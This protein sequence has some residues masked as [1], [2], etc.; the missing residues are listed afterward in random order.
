MNFIYSFDAYLTYGYAQPKNREHLI[1]EIRLK[2]AIAEHYFYLFLNWWC[3][4]CRT[5][6]QRFAYRDFMERLSGHLTRQ[7]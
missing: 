7:G 2:S 4:L 6:E 5:P 3:L 1:K